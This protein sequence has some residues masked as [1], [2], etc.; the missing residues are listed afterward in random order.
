MRLEV[1]GSDPTI[2]GTYKKVP[3]YKVECKAEDR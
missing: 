2:G 1:V 3:F